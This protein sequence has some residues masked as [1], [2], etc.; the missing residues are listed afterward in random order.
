MGHDLP[1]GATYLSITDFPASK[2]IMDLEWSIQ[3]RALARILRKL[4]HSGRD[5]FGAVDVLRK[6]KWLLYGD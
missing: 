5:P 4:I 3:D 2:Y 6:E 1:E